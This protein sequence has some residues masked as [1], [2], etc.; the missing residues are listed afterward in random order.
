MSSR[1]F[2]GVVLQMKD[3]VNRMVGVIDSD[4]YVV[5][6]SELT[7]IGEH[8]AGAVEAVNHA[9]NGV[10]Y[11]EGKTLRPLA[12][13]GSQFDYAAFVKGDDDVAASL[14]AM[15]VVAFNGAKAYYEEKHDKATFV[16][17]IISDNILLGDI[18]TQ[19]K[20][21]HFLSEAPRAAFL[22]RQMGPADASIIDV[23]QNLFPDKQTDFVVSINETDVALIK[24]MPEGADAKELQDL[25]DEVEDKLNGTLLGSAMK[26][27]SYYM[28]MQATKTSGTNVYT[29][30]VV[31]EKLSTAQKNLYKG[32]N[33]SQCID[34]TLT[35]KDAMIQAY[36]AI[37]MRDITMTKVDT[38]YL[39]ETRTVLRTDSTLYGMPYTILQV[40][41]FDLGEYSA[42]ITVAC[43]GENSTAE[44][45]AMF[46]KI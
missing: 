11:F 1:M 33:D 18:Y 22:V 32:K 46:E 20:E 14:C 3:S 28:D 36:E 16:K 7:S 40:L 12:G 5:A 39:G 15:A 42:S 30:N 9:D 41:Y 21:L 25:P 17:N 10:A 26:N 19:A 8:W 35:S 37:G 31:M 2:Q 24:Q 27:V 38:G 6:C 43:V 29:I 4:G 23:I 45:L 34:V 44:L 13:W